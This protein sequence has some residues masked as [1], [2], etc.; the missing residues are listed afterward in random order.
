[1]NKKLTTAILLASVMMLALVG[2][3]K[4]KAD[5]STLA[6]SAT[7]AD[8]AEEE[9]DSE[10]NTKS[11]EKKG[12]TLSSSD[13]SFEY[14]KKTMSLFD[15]TDSLLETLKEI[16]KPDKDHTHENA[17]GGINIY[18][19]DPNKSKPDAPGI[20]LVTYDKDGT[21]TPGQIEILKDGFKTPQGVG[22]GSTKDEVI[23]AYG[24]PDRTDSY[25]SV[26]VLTYEGDN[27]SIQFMIEGTVNSVMYLNHDYFDG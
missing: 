17:E 22:I 8:D 19:F 24:T 26:N 11:E 21:E 15:D 6:S 23:E 13:T 3:G 2:C 20:T 25:G 12:P 18:C 5:A 14:G 9:K 27:F 4:K 16:A 10:E 1:M 7:S